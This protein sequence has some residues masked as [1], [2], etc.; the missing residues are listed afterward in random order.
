MHDLDSTLVVV[1]TPP[2]RGGIG[3]LRLS[4][5]E[6]ERIGRQL[7][8]PARARSKAVGN[9]PA[10]G[11]FLD[12]AGRPID[13]GF[14]VVFPPF[15]SYTGEA[16]VELW[17]HGSPAVLAEMLD[18]AVAL[19][20]RPAGPGE[21]TYRALRNGRLDL[22]QAE[23]IRDLID[24][25]TAYQ[26]RVAFSQAEG[27]LSRRLAPLRAVL[28]DYVARGEAAV[29]FVEEADTCLRDGAIA[30]T[31]ER[32]RRECGELLSA[33]EAG[34]VVRSGAIVAITGRPNVGKS[35]IFNRLLGRDRSIVTEIPGTT[36]DTVEEDIDLS[37]I[38]ARLVDTAG[39][40][41]AEDPVE[42]EGVR[43]A[44]VARREADV[45]VLVL[46]GSRPIEEAEDR[47]IKDAR[48]PGT[49]TILVRNK[50]DLPRLAWSARRIEAIDVS[51]RNGEGLAALREAIARQLRES[52][53]LEDPIL[54][55]ARHA[56]AVR[57]ADQALA[58]AADGVRNGLPDDLVLEDIKLALRHLEEITGEFT[59]EHLLDRIF[60]TFCIGK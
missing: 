12:R 6:A 43:R 23:A 16:S 42:T 53:P 46:D 2:G 52:G 60:S 19:G 49:R 17:A 8:L 11:R 41:E 22:S 37:G 48:D 59:T 10:F 18:F 7:F 24:S 50:A 56:E 34:R 5:T 1:G 21:F 57:E 27:A 54:T 45:V 38:P 15:R 30:E 33:F 40:R 25:R 20:A 35:S 32:G 36:R 31:L 4:G 51:A 3:C 13:H 28:E 58:R 26:A 9:G 39:L 55:N 44:E 29:E 47:A 14:L